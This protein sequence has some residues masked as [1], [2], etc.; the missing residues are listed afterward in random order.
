MA[1]VVAISGASGYLGSHLCHAFLESG[2]EV[3]ALKRRTS[4]LAR[5]G[6]IRSGLRLQDIDAVEDGALFGSGPQPEIVIH[7]AT[8]YGR[9]GES[10]QEVFDANLHFPM[11]LLDAAAN[12]GT[13]IFLN[14]DTVLPSSIN[15]YAQSKADFR[16]RATQR[17]ASSGMVFVNVRAAN[18]Y[19]PWDDE[20]KFTT[21]VIRS[22]AANVPSL[23]LTLGEQERDFVYVDDAARAFVLIARST[24]QGGH[25][26]QAS[27]WARAAARRSGHSPRRLIG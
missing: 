4:N 11:R 16:L 20:T 5:L 14:V 18:M 7:A 19:G 27:I 10:R 23:D 22:C 21:H 12:A 26:R 3:T 13:R 1:T 24:L 2:F 15:D 6:D 9:R 25:H 17:A 8:S